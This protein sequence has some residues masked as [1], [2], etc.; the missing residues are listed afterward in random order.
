MKHKYKFKLQFFP[1]QV[2]GYWSWKKIQKINGHKMC[3]QNMFLLEL[4]TFKLQCVQ[5]LIQN[6]KTP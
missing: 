3:M 6:F 2:R 5:L 4:L 1:L